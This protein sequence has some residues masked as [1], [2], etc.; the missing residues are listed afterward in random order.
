MTEK[1]KSWSSGTTKGT[2][3]IESVS[4]TTADGKTI[5]IVRSVSESVSESESTT[6]PEE[7]EQK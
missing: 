3:I 5:T 6:K 1:N 7:P 2:S 4:E